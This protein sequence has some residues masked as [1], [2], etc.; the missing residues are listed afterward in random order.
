MSNDKDFGLMSFENSNS[1]IIAT[2]VTFH[3]VILLYKIHPSH[4][5]A[6]FKLSKNHIVLIFAFIQ[7][8]ISH[9]Y[10]DS[11]TDFIEIH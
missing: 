11:S 5:I 3:L 9:I 4:H 7:D 1:F 10:I 6:I 8:C 2:A